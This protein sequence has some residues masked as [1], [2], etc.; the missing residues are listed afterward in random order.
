LFCQLSIADAKA[1]RKTKEWNWGNRAYATN[2]VARSL[3]TIWLVL[4][5]E[6]LQDGITEYLTQKGGNGH[7]NHVKLLLI[8]LTVE[9]EIAANIDELVDK[10][11]AE[12]L[13]SHIPQ[14]LQD[15][16][17]EHKRRLEEVQ[18]ELHNSLVQLFSR[19]LRGSTH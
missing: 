5:K 7:Q 10:R 16:V 1:E 14:D 13:E 11:V 18:R 17:T 8:S 15:Q 3:L 9:Q 19:K 12:C 6:L 4:L 2:N